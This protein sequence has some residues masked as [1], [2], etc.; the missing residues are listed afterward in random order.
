MLPAFGSRDLG[1]IDKVLGELSIPTI[2]SFKLLTISY[3]IISYHII[4]NKP[5][6]DSNMKEY[7]TPYKL[8]VDL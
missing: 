5:D 4:H 6:I 8:V 3:H 2:R 7:L 1:I